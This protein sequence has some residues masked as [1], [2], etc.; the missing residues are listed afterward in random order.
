MPAWLIPTADGVRLLIRVQPR[1]SRTEIVGEH[2]GRLKLRLKA[3]PV[4]GAANQALIAF[5][6]KRLRLP[7]NQ[8]TISSGATGRSKTVQVTG[9]EVA[10]LREHLGV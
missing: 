8:I 3:P 5:L 9:I 6:A 2:D 1:A 10:A 4:D 7:K